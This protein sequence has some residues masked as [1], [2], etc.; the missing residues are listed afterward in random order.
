LGNSLDE[1][2]IGPEAPGQTPNPED[3]L[4]KDS[5]GRVKRQAARFR[6]YAYDDKDDVVQEITAQN[7]TINW[8]V[9]LVNKKADGYRFQ[10]RYQDSQ[11][12]NQKILRNSGLTGADRTKLIIDP[13][14]RSVSGINQTGERFKFDTG[15]CF[16]VKV[17]LGEIRTD[18]KGRLLV[19][20]GFGHSASVNNAPITNYANNDNWFDDT[21]DGPVTATVKLNSGKE[22]PV[23]DNAWVIAAPP[24]FAPYHHPIIS[25]YD[26]MKEVA[27]NQ[28]WLLPSQDKVSFTRDIYPIFA[29]AIGYRWLNSAAN[30]GHGFSSSGNFV[31]F[32]NDLSDNSESK[33]DLRKKVFDRVRN[34]ELVLQPESEEAKHQASPTYMPQ[35]SGDDGDYS[36]GQIRTWLSLLPSQYENMRKWKDGNFESDWKGQPDPVIQEFED[37]PLLEQPSALDRASLE[38]C[39]GGPFFPGIEMTYIAW[40]PSLYPGKPFRL[41]SKLEPGDITKHMAVPW[42]A[43]FYECNTDW[44]PA[45]RPDD[46]IPEKEYLEIQKVWESDPT[47]KD[48]K[49]LNKISFANMLA[50]SEPWDRGLPSH[51]DLALLDE[52]D[53]DIGLLGDRYMVKYWSNLG[54]I[55]PRKAPDGDTIFI[56]AERDRYAGIDGIDIREYFYIMMNIESHPEFLSKARILADEFLAETWALQEHDQN[57]PDNYRYFKYSR[58]A[59]IARMDEI[60][61]DLID[62]ANTYDPTQDQNFRTRQQVI[63]GI[64]YMAPFNQL[65]GAWLRNIANGSPIDQVR[66]LLFEI[67]MDEQGD[68]NQ[69]Q[70]HSTLYTELLHKLGSD[71]PHIASYEYAH[72][73][74]LLDSSY[75]TPLFELVISQFTE[76]YFPEILGMTLHLEW[77]VVGL[78]PF[79]AQLRHFDI[80]PHFYVMHVG[81]D[82][83]VN[84]HGAKAKEAIMLYL[85]QI[86]ETAGE[87]TMQ[88]VWKRI[89][90]GYIAFAEV[91]SLGNDIIQKL[92]NDS[93]EKRVVDMIE[94][95]KHY[96]SLNHGNKT[97]GKSNYRINDLFNR[98]DIF[99]K[100]LVEQGYLIPGDPDNSPFFT[101]LGFEGPMYKVFTDE[102]I[103]LWK[104][105]VRSLTSTT[106]KESGQAMLLL[107]NNLQHNSA[108][109]ESGF[110]LSI[111]G[112]D[113]NTGNKV[114]RPISWWINQ[115][116]PGAFLQAL[117]SSKLII[118]GK[119]DKSPFFTNWISQTSIFEQPAVLKTDDNKYISTGYNSWRDVVSQWI[120]DGC[121]IPP[122]SLRFASLLAPRPTSPPTPSPSVSLSTRKR[123]R[124]LRQHTYA[125]TT[126]TT[127]IIRG[128]GNVH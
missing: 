8:S 90:N 14:P 125:Q 3:G 87:D 17:P 80:D 108:L 62:S 119:P 33:S 41:N 67:W 77:E 15:S 85:D 63:E 16:D 50:N 127:G 120:S 60:Y 7:A 35:L 5:N 96:G 1:Y 26:V 72:N 112:I 102:E 36:L 128:N 18:E 55:V 54:F 6:I 103:K 46:V 56:E 13:G 30:T 27:I 98:P 110:D 117:A 109:I 100:Q 53:L 2:F 126:E 52:A 49:K 10:S 43:D 20:G 65:D 121:P 92:N 114:T 83:A 91:G 57:F 59:F 115:N 124:L 44:W 86:S 12:D 11:E 93:L 74:S 82:N 73:K 32:I 29:K 97:L 42:Q 66:S 31:N 39:I 64:L 116:Q 45:A 101:R 47:Y 48:P 69:N 4:F 70:N 9:H 88:H 76:F 75:I 38:M 81:I 94:R 71:L 22:I 107:V 37:V 19:L 99:I 123:K 79:I 84:G 122:L 113:L 118:S 28:K 40:D 21:A 58:D 104:D 24:K 68:G 105:Y 95:K 25:L 106:R 111:T 61:N 78:K 51:S 89:W 34:P 23:K